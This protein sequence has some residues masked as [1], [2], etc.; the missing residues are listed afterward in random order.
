MQLST[1]KINCHIFV[2]H[3]IDTNRAPTQTIH[4]NFMTFLLIELPFYNIPL[5]AQ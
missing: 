2:A 5:L 3:S 4:A 1:S